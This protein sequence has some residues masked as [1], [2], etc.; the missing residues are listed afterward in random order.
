MD[1]LPDF[2]LRMVNMKLAYPALMTAVLAVAGCKTATQ[3]S[4]CTT[5]CGEIP[6]R[7][8]VCQ[9]TNGC[10][11]ACHDSCAKAGCGKACHT[12]GC[13][14]AGCGKACHNNSC[15]KACT[16]G[17]ATAKGC[18][19]ACHKSAC[20]TTSNCGKACHGNGCANVS[21]NCAATCC[22]PVVSQ[23]VVAPVQSTPAQVAPVQPAPA[24]VEQIPT[25]KK[26]LP[27]PPKT[28][29]PKIQKT[30]ASL[31]RTAPVA[32]KPVAMFGHSEDYTRLVGVLQR[33]HTPGAE[34]KLRYATLDQ[35]DKWG[36]SVVLAED[37][38]LDHYQ[39][40]DLVYAEG[41]IL[42]ERA[43]TFV[44]GPLFRANTIRK[45]KAS[46]VSVQY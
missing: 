22:A 31:R 45:P 8:T 24:K 29:E 11:K 19:K 17:C 36:G 3:S 38:R 18:G 42:K 34:W 27:E 20:A 32:K 28:D 35:N 5:T 2:S 13:A 9:P 33:I 40:G 1:P 39:D 4:C 15:G 26:E 6:G 44:A 16:P 14:K 12:S 43:S 46:D 37:A 30:S 7:A 23:P 10:G 21:T 41:N 25:E